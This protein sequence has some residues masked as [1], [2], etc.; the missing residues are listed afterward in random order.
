MNDA[1]IKAFCPECGAQ[2]LVE[3]L[4]VDPK[5]D[6]RVFCPEHGTVGTR[7]TMDKI[8]VQKAADQ[9]GKQFGKDFAEAMKDIGFDVQRK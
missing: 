4:G 6:D 2:L 3:R 1:N 8:V 5:P 9:F 7:E